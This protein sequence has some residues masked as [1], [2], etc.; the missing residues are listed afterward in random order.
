MPDDGSR[1]SAAARRPGGEATAAAILQAAQEQFLARGYHATSMRQIAGAAGSS[2]GAL[3]HHFPTKEA[4]FEALLADRNVYPKIAEAFA[5]VQG[6]TV[7]ILLRGAIAAVHAAVAENRDFIRLVFVDVLEFEGAH[8][9]KLAMETLPAMLGLFQKVVT[10]GEA[11]GEL[12]PLQPL[13]LGLSFMGAILL[14]N[15]AYLAL[16]EAASG[17]FGDHW[18]EEHVDIVLRGVLKPAATKREVNG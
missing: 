17:L 16:G 18:Q 11:R 7:E 10:V 8:V 12:R 6:D 2:L 15:L 14:T 9:R 1:A 3:Y 13:A 5:G 4:I